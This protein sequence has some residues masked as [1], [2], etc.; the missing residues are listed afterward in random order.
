[1][2]K[3]MLETVN[4]MYSAFSEESDMKLAAIAAL[5]EQYKVPS[6]KLFTLLDEFSV[7]VTHASWAARLAEELEA[8]IQLDENDNYSIVK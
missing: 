4:D 7:S 5:C 2:T 8:G 3:T 6:G 1:M